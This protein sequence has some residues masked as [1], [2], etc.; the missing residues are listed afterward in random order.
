MRKIIATVFVLFSFVAQA[1]GYGCPVTAEC[2]ID[3]TISTQERCVVG[4]NNT[5][6]C[7]Y[8]H[9]AMDGTVHRF[10]VTNCK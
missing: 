4:K 5:Q 7:L 1:F 8:R 2:P 6:S 10:W 9:N 3:G